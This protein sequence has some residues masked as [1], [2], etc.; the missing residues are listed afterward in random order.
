[1]SEVSK[2]GIDLSKHVNHLVALDERGREI[3]KKKLRRGQMLSWFANVAACTVVMEAC[4]GAHYWARELQRLGHEVVLIPP[5]V[6]RAYVQG[7]KNDYNDARAV[8]EASRRAGLRPVAVKTPEQ[9]SLQSLHRMRQARIA[10]RTKLCNQLRA[11]L[12][13][14]GIAIPKGVATLKRAL[15]EVLEDADNGL[16]PLARELLNQGRDELLRLEESLRFYDERIQAQART[17]PAQQRLQSVPGFGPILASAFH[18]HIGDG[19][20]FARG[21]DVSAA[22]GL[23]PAQHTSGDRP[24]LLGISK[25]GDRYVRSLLVH[26]AR[27]VLRCAQGKDDPLSQWIQRLIATRGKN[28]A[29][30]ALA[31]K[32][33]RM[34]WAVLRH[35]TVYQPN[36]GRRA[37]PVA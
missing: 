31:N 4:A 27:A 11:L 16:D 19:A 7:N 14:H 28:K 20:A 1:M 8:L 35:D 32:M 13:E 24:Y 36:L 17:Q 12:G 34:G 3:W 29:T 33:A 9:L 2:I 6:V 30:V 26:G 25:R 23:V 18:G 22:L 15:A 5:R 21:R 10:E 37:Q